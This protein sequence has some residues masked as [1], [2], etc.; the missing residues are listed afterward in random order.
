MNYVRRSHKEL[1]WETTFHFTT[2]IGQVL[3]RFHFTTRI[4]QI[5]FNTC[6]SRGLLER[7]SKKT[8]TSM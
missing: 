3:V 1:V 5:L 7:F 8:V 2:R 4:G 6:Q